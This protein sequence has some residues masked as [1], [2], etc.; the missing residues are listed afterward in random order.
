MNNK[1]NE[2]ILQSFINI[3][4]YLSS[5]LEEEISFALTDKEKF[6]AF[7]PSENIRPDIKVG[8]II[9]KGSSTY[10]AIRTKSIVTKV[11]EEEVFDFKL[12]SIAV[13]IEGNNGEI[14]GVVSI[15]KS[16]KKQENMLNLSKNLSEASG[17]IADAINEVSEGVQNT[18]SLNEIVLKEAT[19]AF[20]KTL[21]SNEIINFIKAIERQTNLL[22]LNASIEAARAGEY[23]KSF[24]VVA[25]EIRKLSNSS[26]ESITKINDII[27]EIQTSVKNI[28]DSIQKINE[29]FH[30]QAAALEEITASIQDLNSNAEVLEHISAQ[31]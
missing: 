5:L 14:V 28:S 29:T 25:S 20:E 12:K 6:I 23:G 4:P 2:G 17:Q 21:N 9:K 1:I 27:N 18:A 11:I 7:S 30:N 26:S 3:S 15:G 8:D 13:P 24:S 10:D 22:G 19:E 16:L 31:Y